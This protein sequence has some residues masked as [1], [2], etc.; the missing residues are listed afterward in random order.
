M[1][2]AILTKKEAQKL[3][4]CLKNRVNSWVVSLDLGKSTEK[5]ELGAD[6]VLLRGEKISLKV[7]EKTKED[8]CYITQEGKLLSVDFFS[9]ETNLFYKLKPTKDWPTLTLSSVPMHRFKHISPKQDT[10]SKINELGRVSGCV[11]DTCCGLGYTAIMNAEKKEVEEV[12]VFEKDANV[13]RI[14]EH[15][16]YSEE[17]F[18]NKKIELRNENVFEG[19]KSLESEYFAGIIH[20]PPTTSFAPELYSP[21]FYKELFRVLKTGGVLYHYCPNPGKTKGKEFYPTIIKLLTQTG[22]KDC[23]YSEKSSGV[24]AIKR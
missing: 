7:L 2:Q 21:E 3:V 15:N 19:V 12:I 16:P 5:V 10:L 14:A 20:D 18:T 17:L 4:N 6:F 1:K 23:K 11:L 13:L 24:K 22:F 8:T 9:N